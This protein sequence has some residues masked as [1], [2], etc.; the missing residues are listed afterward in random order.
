MVI[1]SASKA[2]TWKWLLTRCSVNLFLNAAVVASGWL[3]SP[4]RMLEN[5]RHSKNF[6]LVLNVAISRKTRINGC[7]KSALIP[8]RRKDIFSS[9]IT[10]ANHNHSE[11]TKP[12]Y[13]AVMESKFNPPIIPPGFVPKHKFA[14]P[15]EVERKVSEVAP[16]EGAPPDDLELRMMIDGLA[17]FVA[18]SGKIFEDLS[19]EK[20]ANNPLFC[21]LF[22][23]PGHDYY[24]RK[25]WEEQRKL[26]ERG[27]SFTENFHEKKRQNLSSEERGRVL[28]ETPLERSSK[29]ANAC[30]PPGDVARLQSVL[31]DTFT[32]PTSLLEGAAAIRPFKADPSKQARFEQFLKDKYQGGLRSTHIEDNMSE[33]QRAQER[34]DF[35]AAAEMIAKGIQSKKNSVS[36]NQQLDLVSAVGNR[37]TSG[38]VEI[39]GSKLQERG[40]EKVE[41]IET[42]R[43]PRREEH[44]WRPALL[45]CK[46]F[47]LLDPY[48]GK[49]LSLE[50]LRKRLGYGLRG[51]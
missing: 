8:Y 10:S 26:V 39:M 25:L 44:Q 27:K 24:R 41:N 43:L 1:G 33:L 28:G 14:A 38:G 30:V 46:R 37:F 4:G 36:S 31:S 3:Y 13:T 17:T 19:R 21:F 29:S 2:Y 12:Q 23:G 20:N 5:Y 51:L 48:A 32:K 7:K 18:R 11:S 45:L 15:L 42:K 47:N 6:H 22:G 35:E 34:V 9:K 49:V 50:T 16:P 40:H